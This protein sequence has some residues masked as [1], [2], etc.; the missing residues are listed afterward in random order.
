MFIIS[1]STATALFGKEDPI[2][3][4]IAQTGIGNPQWGEIVGIAADV[5]SVLPDPGPVTLQLYQPMA[6]DP[7]PYNEIAVRTTGVAPSTL[8]Q[9]IKRCDDATRP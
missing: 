9:S 6:Q 7:R 2:G 8:V 3:R 4:R 1:Q 5:K